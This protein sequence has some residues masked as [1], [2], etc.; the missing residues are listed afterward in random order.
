VYTFLLLFFAMKHVCSTL[1][2]RVDLLKARVIT[3]SSLESDELSYESHS[4]PMWVS[5]RFF[6]KN[7]LSTLLFPFLSS[8]RSSS[9]AYV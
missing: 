2:K 8:S 4:L 9:S 5:P 3:P 7:F 6:L 1:R